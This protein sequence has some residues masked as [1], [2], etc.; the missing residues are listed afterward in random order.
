MSRSIIKEK[1]RRRRRKGMVIK[2]N[3]ITAKCGIPSGDISDFATALRDKER[4]AATVCKYVHDVR[5]FAEWLGEEPPSHSV[6]LEYK[7]KLT[8]NYSPATVNSVIASLNCFFDYTGRYEL[9]FRS[10]RLQ[11]PV[12]MSGERELA[13]DEYERLVR[14]ARNKGK[15]RLLTIM[16]TIC[17]TGIRISELRFITVEAVRRGCADVTCKGKRR[18]V[19]LPRRLVI[20]LK[21]YIKNSGISHGALF[22]TR[23]GKNV[24]RS[25]IW[26][27]MKKLCRAAGVES[28]KVFP[29]N[30]RHLF[31]RVFYEVHRDIV[32]LADILG[33]SSVNT[34]RIYTM[35][36][37]DEHRRRIDN[38]GLLVFTT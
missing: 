7:R 22:V 34:T 14:A 30:L 19:L 8:E 3:D 23:G 21:E 9:K 16:Q 25:N 36:S 32:R 1:S 13:R 10:V 5:V 17:S 28:T 11:R 27:E 12:F 26:S 38:L 33:H 35:E 18:Q 24:D 6:V 15:T 4:S 29:H 37:S 20:I 31:A 2:M